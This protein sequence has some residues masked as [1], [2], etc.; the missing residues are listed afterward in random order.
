MGVVNHGN[1]L[2]QPLREKQP[3]ADFLQCFK[4]LVSQSLLQMTFA[5][6]ASHQNWH[7][8]KEAQTLRKNLNVEVDK[9]ICLSLAIG[10]DNEAYISSD[11]PF[12]DL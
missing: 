5:C 8:M 6:M 9:L 1:S 3:Q 10:V 12:K 7:K 2:C 4:N 11:F